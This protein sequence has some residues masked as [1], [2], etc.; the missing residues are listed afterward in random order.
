[1]LDGEYQGVEVE[2]M[3]IISSIVVLLFLALNLFAGCGATTQVDSA[4]LA[5]GTSPHFVSLNNTALPAE[6]ATFYV[7]SWQQAVN[8]WY[9]VYQPRGWE[10]E[11]PAP[12]P[13]LP[14]GPQSA[15]SAT[16][17]VLNDPNTVHSTDNTKTEW[18]WTGLE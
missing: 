11:T 17:A 8:D 5:R 16:T 12:P 4:D 15:S 13:T 10:G 7:S 2:V 9:G 3:R 18:T 14:P 1:M 6:L